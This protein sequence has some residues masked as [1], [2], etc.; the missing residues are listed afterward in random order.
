MK[1]IGL[2]SYHLK[3]YA[4]YAAAIEAAGGTPILIENQSDLPLTLDA[5]VIPGG[6]DINPAL[7]RAE[8]TTSFDIDD[9]LDQLEWQAIRIY[10]D[11]QRPIL[12]I[13]RGHQLLNAF[14]G[15]SLIQ[16]VAHTDIHQQEN[17][18]DKVHGSRVE[19][20]S[21][22][23]NIYQKEHIFTNSAHHQAIGKL[24]K[25]LSPVQYSDDGLIEAF[26]HNTLPIYGVQW[27]PER[28]CLQNARQDTVD[29]LKIFQA[30]TALIP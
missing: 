30:F 14:F 4:N 8:N 16:N 26:A 5:L 1:H 29:G 2:I 22:L 18:K 19:K 12:G 17:G 27:H 28:M 9:T 15:G 25:D 20:V 6:A 11:K 10:A 24:G 23:Y 3:T 13:C 21:F 7:Y